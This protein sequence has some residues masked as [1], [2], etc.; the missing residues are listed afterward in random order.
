M[1]EAGG[2]KEEGGLP[3]L[4]AALHLFPSDFITT[5]ILSLVREC[6]LPRVTLGFPL[7]STG[8]SLPTDSAVQTQGVPGISSALP[9]PSMRCQGLGS[10]VLEARLIRPPLPRPAP[11]P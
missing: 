9:W 6:G 2:C 8:H 1:E 11:L 5:G 4:V 10:F 7:D 3:L